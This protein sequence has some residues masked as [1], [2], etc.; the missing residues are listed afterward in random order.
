[1]ATIVRPARGS[2]RLSSLRMAAASFCLLHFP[3]F[4][5]MA[6]VRAPNYGYL[7]KSDAG[8]QGTRAGIRMERPRANE[9]GSTKLGHVC[10]ESFGA[11]LFPDAPS[12]LLSEVR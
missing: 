6:H 9:Q 3:A 10:D 1:M 5:A 8:N 11:A 7:R 2:R 12:L 4:E